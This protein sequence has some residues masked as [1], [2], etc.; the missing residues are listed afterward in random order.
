MSETSKVGYDEYDNEFL[1]PPVLTYIFQFRFQFPFVQIK[2]VILC[3][4]LYF[5]FTHIIFLVKYMHFKNIGIF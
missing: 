2:H 1:I 5:M 3:F 4:S